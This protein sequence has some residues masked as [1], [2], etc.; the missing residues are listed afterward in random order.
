MVSRMAHP[1]T[2]AVEGS[3]SLAKEGCGRWFKSCSGTSLSPCIIIFLLSLSLYV[4][5]FYWTALSVAQTVLQS[6]TFYYCHT[7]LNWV[8]A[9]INTQHVKKPENFVSSLREMRKLKKRKQ[10]TFLNMRSVFWCKDV[11][12]P[13][14]YFLRTSWNRDILPE[15]WG[16]PRGINLS[17]RGAGHTTSTLRIRATLPP[18]PHAFKAWTLSTGQKCLG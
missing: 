7:A 11:R 9:N 15:T 13:R 5:V 10:N 1:G 4:S 6:G 8:A 12:G 3:N 14:I 18:L 16:F 2:T 17:K